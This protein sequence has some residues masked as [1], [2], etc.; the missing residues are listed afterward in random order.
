[1]PLQDNA[2]RRFAAGRANEK[3]TTLIEYAFVIGLV[4]LGIGFLLP[5][6]LDSVSRVF[7]SVTNSVQSAATK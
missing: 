6:I 4:S 5:E 7:S 1:M 2:G 3:G